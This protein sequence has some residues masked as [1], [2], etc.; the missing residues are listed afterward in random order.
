MPSSFLRNGVTGNLGDHSHHPEHGKKGLIFDQSTACAEP[1]PGYF[2]DMHTGVS[3]AIAIFASCA[4]SWSAVRLE[5]ISSGFD[6]P[7]WVGM[8]KHSEGKLWVMEQAGKIWVLDLKTGK[9]QD[10][11]FLD[12]EAKVT[13]E[14]NEQ[15]MLGLAFDPNFH[16]SGRYYVNYTNKQ[17]QTCISR[18]FSKDGL[19][20]SAD[21]EEVLLQFAQPY[22][23][24]NG[25]WIEFGP[26]GMLYI[27]S[28]DGGSGNDPQ[29]NGQSLNTMLGKILRIDAS[30][31]TGYKI[32]SDNPFI[33]DDKAKS[34]IWAYGIRNPWRC[35]FDRETKDFWIGDVGQNHW[36]EI[37][38]M[39]YGK[40][41]GANYGWRLREGLVATPKKNIGGDKPVGHVDPVYVY[42]HGSGATEGLSVT[43]GYVYRGSA[44]PELKGRYIFADFQQP[45]I[46]SF[47]IENG[48]AMDFTD[49]SKAW[50]PEG[51]PFNLIA[52]FA[53]DNA[54]ELYV[55]CLTG[56]IYKLTM[57]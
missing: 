53:E 12:I 54:G 49:H 24:H 48:K 37:N 11:A 21:T 8:P 20:S 52:S 46:W 30:P 55:V 35:S 23:N 28:G 3:T 32:P 45:R 27:G 29:G 9:R 4:C 17:E 33:H 10:Q 19:S 47:R 16:Q 2:G 39:P 44:I 36:E 40:G 31:K 14:G 41:A 15:G 57:R 56:H 51:E 1:S 38:Y 13:R 5:S 25:G 18:F 50:Q 34:E 43:G 26:D 6:R 42:P 7:V 22:K